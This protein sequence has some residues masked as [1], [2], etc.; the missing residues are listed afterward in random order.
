MSETTLCGHTGRLVRADML[1]KTLVEQYP[2][3]IRVF[4]QYRLHCVGCQISGF[5]T[6]TDTARE[7]STEIEPLLHDLNLAVLSAAE[8]R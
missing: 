7:H 6:I 3:T 5:H 4:I 1:V 8:D 2:E